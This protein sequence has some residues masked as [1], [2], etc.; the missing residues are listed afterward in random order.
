MKELLDEVKKDS[1]EFHRQLAEESG[2]DLEEEELFG[3]ENMIKVA[4]LERELK[5]KEKIIEEKEKEIKKLK[6]Q[7][8]KK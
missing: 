4:D 2:I 6:E 1:E 7:L 3:V 8:K 5:E